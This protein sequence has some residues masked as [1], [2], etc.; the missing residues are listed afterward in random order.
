MYHRTK[1]IVTLGKNSLNEKCIKDLIYKGAVIFR[2]NFSHGTHEE[3]KELIRIRKKLEKQTAL[4]I[5][6]IADI[7]GPELR[8]HNYSDQ[9][10]LKKNQEIKIFSQHLLKQSKKE[11][12]HLNINLEKMKISESQK[13]RFMDGQ[14]EGEVTHYCSDFITVKILNNGILRANAHC[15]F[16]GLDYPLPF[17]S[18]KDIDDIQFSVLNHFDALALSFIKDKNDIL[19]AKALIKKINAKS[20]IAIIAKFELPQSLQNIDAILKTADACFVARGDL[21]LENSFPRIPIIQKQICKK[22]IEYAKPVFIAT[23]MLESMTHQINP[24]RAEISDIANAVF[25]KADALTLSGET[26]IGEYPVESV[27]M[28][29]SIIYETENFIYQKNNE[30]AEIFKEK[31]NCKFVFNEKEN[32]LLLYNATIDE[33]RKIVA[34]RMNLLTYAISN[35]QYLYRQYNFY[36]GLIPIYNQ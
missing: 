34:M 13:V 25:D 3:A 14:I 9:L 31:P 26:A 23:Q 29:C 35:D 22:A 12:I 6:L 21:A 24:N 33:I 28:M 8:I 32:S 10:V 17:L 19:S 11:S 16:P 30:L 15:A 36:W 20:K 4:A 5:S 18:D 27:E 2:Y 1:I 7:A